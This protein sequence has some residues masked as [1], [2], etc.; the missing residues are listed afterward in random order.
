M[1]RKNEEKCDEKNKKTKIE[2]EDVIDVDKID[3][4]ETVNTNTKNCGEF[5]LN[6]VDIIKKLSND[7]KMV[8]EK[9][10]N[11]D[12]ILF[13]GVAGTGKSY[14]INILFKCLRLNNKNVYKTSTTGRS[15][16]DIKGTTIHNFC[17]IGKGDGKLEDYKKLKIKNIIKADILIIDEISMMSM[18]LFDLLDELFKYKRGNDYFFG[19]TQLILCGD[20]YQLKPID[21]R[22]CFESSAFK[23]EIKTFIELKKVFRQTDEKWINILYQIRNANL[24]QESIKE[25]NKRVKKPDDDNYI[26]IYST[27]RDVDAINMKELEK[28][29]GPEYIFK[30]KEDLFKNSESLK[31]EYKVEKIITLKKGCKVMLTDNLDIS[32]GLVNGAIGYVSDFD[33]KDG[34]PIIRFN[35]KVTEK[36][37]PRKFEIEQNDKI[38]ARILQLPLKLSYAITIHKS[39]GSTFEKIRGN[40]TKIF[41]PSQNYVFFSRCKSLEGVYL[42]DFNEKHIK[43]PDKKVIKFYKDFDQKKIKE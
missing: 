19:G 29:E 28:S 30:A 38:I 27:N 10:L 21:G 22:Y 12:N 36:I 3:N 39:Q 1:K 42:D 6:M 25:L 31:H 34:Y 33:E 26:T 8:I 37:I 17:G 13:T 23:K 4:K 14:L 41:D 35:E 20:F 9:A 16:S 11:G 18:E 40:P 2:P 32:L 5:P 24:T 43:E 7:Q 15:A